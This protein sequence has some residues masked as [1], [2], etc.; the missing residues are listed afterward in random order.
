MN[1]QINKDA[2]LNELLDKKRKV[3]IGW[4]KISNR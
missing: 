4:N 1:E 2:Y 3:D